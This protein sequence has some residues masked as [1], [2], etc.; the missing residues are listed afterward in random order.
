M[1]FIKGTSR[2]RGPC[3]R[4]EAAG[5][6]ARACEVINAVTIEA[7]KSINGAGTRSFGGARATIRK[8]DKC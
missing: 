8:I 7:S 4:L 3:Y 5:R 6:I 1:N 2:M